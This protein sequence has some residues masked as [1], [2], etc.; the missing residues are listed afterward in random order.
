MAI[1]VCRY[2][3][4][5]NLSSTIAQLA[6]AANAASPTGATG[7][8]GTAGA[9]GPAGPV[10]PAATNF[11]APSTDPHVV[12]AVWNNNGRLVISAG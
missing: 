3:D 11:I 4:S 12:N 2:Y 7:P 8:A 9:T 10:G 5:G 1:P 6:T